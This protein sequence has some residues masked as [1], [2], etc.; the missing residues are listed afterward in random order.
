[1]TLI[2][3]IHNKRLNRIT[4]TIELDSVN[5]SL[6]KTN[7][8]DEVNASHCATWIINLTWT[9]KNG[10]PISFDVYAYQDNDNI[11]LDHIDIKNTKYK[12]TG[13]KTNF[14]TSILKEHVETLIDEIKTQ[15]DTGYYV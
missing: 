5:K 11:F 8:I 7:F 3:E 4:S 1:M 10:K 9:R 14:D 13:R 12:E 6:F 2:K 15:I